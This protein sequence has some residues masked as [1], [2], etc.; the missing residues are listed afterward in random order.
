MAQVSEMSNS[1]TS[2]ETRS[3]SL[4]TH[5][6]RVFKPGISRES[7]S[8]WSRTT[9]IL[10]ASFLIISIVILTGNKFCHCDKK[11]LVVPQEAGLIPNVTTNQANLKSNKKNDSKTTSRYKEKLV[12]YINDEIERKHSKLKSTPMRPSKFDYGEDVDFVHITNMSS[13]NPTKAKN[14]ASKISKPGEGDTMRLIEQM[15]ELA[16]NQPVSSS[17]PS[18]AVGNGK[19]VTDSV[20][21]M[22]SSLLN[23]N[24]IVTNILGNYMSPILGLRAFKGFAEQPDQ[25]SSQDDSADKTTLPWYSSR[26]SPF[27]PRSNSFKLDNALRLH[28]LAPHVSSL[29][30]HNPS[31]IR[32]ASTTKSHLSESSNKNP[33][34]DLLEPDASSVVATISEPETDPHQISRNSTRTRKFL[35]SARKFRSTLDPLLQV[36]IKNHLTFGQLVQLLSGRGSSVTSSKNELDS[37][38]NTVRARA[39][40]EFFRLANIINA[41]LTSKDDGSTGS[42]RNKLNGF[43]QRSTN[44]IS[45]SNQGKLVKYVQ[46]KL[47]SVIPQ[48]TNALTQSRARPRGIMWEM[49]TDPSLAVTVF[50]LLE[51]ASVA[52]P[53]GE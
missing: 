8:P 7:R 6:G 46:G 47:K 48:S 18:N 11:T 34:H 39:F 30:R 25:A 23:S 35:G 16:A 40:D 29:L 31:G 33:E 51:R 45:A 10:F 27:I 24:K 1:I 12:A 26:L 43:N 42:N 4:G 13:L 20:R 21:L 38:E 36:S 2:N 15:H 17:Q 5:R 22:A 3:K 37:I 53:L 19:R 28:S 32:G 44:V 52:L 41:G 50:H 49:A 9:S 14:Q